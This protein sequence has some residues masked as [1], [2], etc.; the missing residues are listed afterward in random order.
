MEWRMNELTI[1]EGSYR[2]NGKCKDI[3][4][5]ARERG[6]GGMGWERKKE[7]DRRG[8]SGLQN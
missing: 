2:K 1:V 8:G 5:H 6:T 7:Q 4:G 3:A